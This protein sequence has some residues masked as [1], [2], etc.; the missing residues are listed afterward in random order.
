M[1]MNQVLVKI[2]TFDWKKHEARIKELIHKK[3][4]AVGLGILV[5]LVV[6]NLVGL[7]STKQSRIIEHPTEVSFQN[8]RILNDRESTFYY[9][10]EKMLSQK[11]QALIETQAKLE[12]RLSELEKKL[13]DGAAT[14]KPAPTSSPEKIDQA[15]PGASRQSSLAESVK[16]AKVQF[17]DPQQ[18][19]EGS[20]VTPLGGVGRGRLNAKSS[21]GP[22]L[23][24]FP[25][26]A[27]AKTDGVVLPA[28]SY[29]KAKILTGVEVPEGKTYPVLMVLDFSY[30]APNDNKI[31]LTGCFMIAKA[32]GDLSTERVQMQATKKGKC[33]S[34]P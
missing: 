20:S 2:K 29:V 15:T 17:F 5:V 12:A 6:V 14:Q 25:V 18:D 1:E 34:G 3:P 30:V 8:G 27:D 28:G 22:D 13:Q 9:G 11:A 26:K 32:E 23:I 24:A 21:K 7:G 4:L 10:K 31:D 19:I 33:L 16:D